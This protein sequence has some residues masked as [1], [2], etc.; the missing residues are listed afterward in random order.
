MDTPNAKIWIAIGL[1][2]TV[3][4]ACGG[5]TGGNDDQAA[6]L[7]ATQQSL[8]ATQA[9]LA[10]EPEPTQAPAAT[11]APAEPAATEEAPAFYTEEFDEVNDLWTYF[12][13]S[14]EDSDL[15]IITEDGQMVFDIQEEQVYA[16]LTYDAYYYEDVRIDTSAR[17]LGSN[18]NN[19]SLIC[20]ETEDG[21]Y[22][23][24]IA[25]NGLY[26]ILRYD[27]D[28]NEY[29]L[30]YNGGSTA[31][32]TGKATNEYTAICEG[33][34]LSLFINGVEARTVD[35]D[36]RYPEGRVGIS[37]SSFENV[38]VTVNFEWVTISEP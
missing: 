18:N 21:W 13:M 3:T 23:F 31:I 9:A 22:E 26:S 20:R 2:I 17:N 25:N 4:I 12:L 11:D 36:N 14:G 8:E 1:L 37:V 10:N 35:H 27:A 19:V 32:N 33:D 29:T 30:I 6:N 38:P 34:T 15:S 16:Y 7:A 5:S 24:N 28:V